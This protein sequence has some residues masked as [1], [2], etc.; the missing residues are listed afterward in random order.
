MDGPGRP[1]PAAAAREPGAGVQALEDLPQRQPL[2]GQPAVEHAHDLGL[3][4][5]DDQ[6]A[7]D[8]VAARQV[9]VAVGGV[10]AD[11]LAGAGL[12]QLAAAEPLAQQRALVLGDGALDLQ[13]ELVAGVVR[14][15]AAEERDRAAGA[16]ELLQEQDLVGVLA[17]QAVGG[18]HGD[19]LDLAVAHGV[20]QRVQAGPVEARAAVALVAEHVPVAQLVALGLGPGAQGGELAVDGLLALLALG[21]DPG[22]GGGAHGAPPSAGGVAEGSAGRSPVAAGPWPARRR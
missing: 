2:L 21:R 22:I 19:D 18:E 13:Q 20:A 16:A 6:P 11:E 8:P 14:D 7:G 5:V 1:G 9:A 3:G 4:L 15:G 17:G 10:H 12:L